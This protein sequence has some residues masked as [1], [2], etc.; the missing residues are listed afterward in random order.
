MGPYMYPALLGEA[1]THNNWLCF[2]VETHLV[3]Y[4]NALFS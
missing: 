2:E 4:L 1:R 3:L